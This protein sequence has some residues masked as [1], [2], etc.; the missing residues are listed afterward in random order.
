MVNQTACPAALAPA[1]HARAEATCG[2]ASEGESA[3]SSAASS[4]V[5]LLGVSE[6]LGRSCKRATPSRSLEAGCD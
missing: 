2:A 3:R 4:L 5:R 1:G 6:A